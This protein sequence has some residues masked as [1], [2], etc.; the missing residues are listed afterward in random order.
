MS[1]S[2]SRHILPI[3]GG[4]SITTHHERA[5]IIHQ[6]NHWGFVALPRF[7][8]VVAQS[9]SLTA[10]QIFFFFLT[11]ACCCQRALPVS[12]RVP[13]SLTHLV[14]WITRLK[15]GAPSVF[16]F[17]TGWLAYWL[18]DDYIVHCIWFYCIMR[19]MKSTPNNVNLSGHP[20]SSPACA[21]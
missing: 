11:L 18:Y 19:F 12:P 4:H 5:R 17:L 8:I 16:V 15:S 14:C 7:F 20:E 6:S 10:S 21:H 9:S 1:H 13:V 2:W 3:P